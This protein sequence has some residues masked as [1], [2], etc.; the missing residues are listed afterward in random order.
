MKIILRK[1]ILLSG[2]ITI[3]FNLTSCSLG[4]FEKFVKGYNEEEYVDD[5]AKTIESS[6]I[7][8]DISEIKEFF[9]ESVIDDCS[10]IDEQ[11]KELH[12]FIDCCQGKG[13]LKRR[14]GPG[15]TGEVVNGTVMKK[16]V[17]AWY[18]LTEQNDIYLLIFSGLLEDKEEPKNVGIHSLCVIKV[19]DE[20]KDA[21]KFHT[22]FTWKEVQS[23]KGIQ[24]VSDY[25][26][27]Y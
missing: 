18:S 4:A 26:Y 23:V 16:T 15:S 13:E 25:K 14:G 24:L 11:I 2:I 21:E 8:K 12:S 19:K 1:I 5:F 9:A 10:D 20:D 3:L 27:H 22:M 17:T 6:C 7:N